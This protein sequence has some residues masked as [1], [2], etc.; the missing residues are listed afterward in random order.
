MVHNGIEYALMQVIAES[1]DL[2][3]RGLRLDNDELRQVYLEWSTSILRSY[4]M[5]ITA[6]IF[7][8]KD[9]DKGRFLLDMILDEAQGKGTGKWTA[10]DAMDIGVPVPT[11]DQAVAFRDLS[12]LREERQEAHKVLDWPNSA[13]REDRQAC[14]DLLGRALE[15]STI[16]IYGQALAQL[17]VA[18]LTYGYGLNLAEVARIWRGGCIIR[19]DVLEPIRVAFLKKP[20]QEPL[21]RPC[22]LKKGERP[23]SRS[24]PYCL[25]ICR[26][27][28]SCPWFS[29]LSRLSGWIPEP[30]AARKPR[31]GATGLFRVPHV[32]TGR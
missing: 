6:R 22:F 19:S 15:V 28:D 12:D 9:A 21:A 27:G 20:D 1:Y 16:I 11:I 29:G 31:T 3:K 23:A 14:I 4:L 8:K 7:A 32:Q 10:Q 2:M 17:R 5:E 30:V 13:L 26:T 24:A 25:S 18:S